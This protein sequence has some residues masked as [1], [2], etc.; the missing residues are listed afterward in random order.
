V[1]ADKKG[2]L[3]GTAAGAI[4]MLRP[5]AKAGQPWKETVL[6]AFNPQDGFIASSPLILSKNVLYG[7]TAQGGTFRSGTVFQLTLP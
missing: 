2:R 1:I 3:F 4:F 6:H 7:T 5:P